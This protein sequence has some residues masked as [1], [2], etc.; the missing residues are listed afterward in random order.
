[1][2][3]CVCVYT[4]DTETVVLSRNIKSDSYKERENNMTSLKSIKHSLI[5]KSVTVG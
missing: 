5:N 1:M 4:A 2:M 3:V